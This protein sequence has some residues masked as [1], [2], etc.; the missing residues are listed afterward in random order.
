[1]YII[2]HFIKKVNSIF[3]FVVM[4]D[5]C[6]FCG[7]MGENVVMFFVALWAK[8]GL[9]CFLWLYGRELDVILKNVKKPHVRVGI[10]W[11]Y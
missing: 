4:K 3:A 7:F 2:H 9:V 6:V 11:G 1:M 8:R 10:T 5:W